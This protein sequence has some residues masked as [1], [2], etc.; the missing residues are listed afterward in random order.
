[1]PAT[2]R[3]SA[4]AA[5]PSADNVGNARHAGGTDVARIAAFAALLAGFGVLSGTWL[6]WSLRRRAH[7]PR[8]ARRPIK[9]S[10]DHW[11]M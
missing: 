5:A 3:A 10:D 7:P 9:D 8:H 6:R 4:Q 1:V 11:P 2:I